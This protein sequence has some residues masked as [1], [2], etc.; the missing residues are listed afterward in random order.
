MGSWKTSLL[1][2]RNYR[3]Q[4]VLL[5]SSSLFI[6][7]VALTPPVSNFEQSPY[8]GYSTAVWVLFTI[9]MSGGITSLITAAKSH[10]YRHIW[11]A[12]LIA[13]VVSYGGLFAIPLVRDYAQYGG[14]GWDTFVHLGYTA[15]ILE[16]AELTSYRYPITHLTFS[17]L[18]LVTDIQP[19]TFTPVVAYIMFILFITSLAVAVRALTGDYRLTLMTAVAAVPIQFGNHI[20][21]IL[22][23]LQ[24]MTLLPL[25]LLATHGFMKNRNKRWA[26]VYLILSATLILYHPMTASIGILFITGY[27]VIN[28]RDGGIAQKQFVMLFATSLGLLGWHLFSGD[29]D[30]VI[31]S[32]ILRLLNPQPG[33][34]S[35]ATGSGLL[36]PP[37]HIAWLFLENYGILAL[38]F[39]FA[40]LIASYLL[41]CMI[42]N[43][44]PLF[45]QFIGTQFV[46]AG[47]VSVGMF[48]FRI[49][50]ENLVRVT[51]YLTLISVLV[52]GI[53]A[54]IGFDKIQQLDRW[55]KPIIVGIYIL[56]IITALFASGTVYT[57]N[58]HITHTTEMGYEWHVDHKTEIKTIDKK[59]R[60][61]MP[62]KFLGYKK[63]VNQ[64]YRLSMIFS[65]P[66]YPHRLGY[67]NN[68]SISKSLKLDPNE[69]MYLVT[70][71]EHIE[72]YRSLPNWKLESTTYY[73]PAD[74]KRLKNDKTANRVYSNGGLEISIIY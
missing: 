45:K 62:F 63:T 49:H 39:I 67:N 42:V 29:I 8:D 2:K 43:N 25:L 4:K 11:P 6:L 23:Y 68:T 38:Y 15:D 10:R 12:G 26:G 51:R 61:A 60:N 36:A 54:T 35:T 70:R 30:G 55:R 64:K 52:V 16:N 34:V 3:V 69:N 5:I 66:G 19:D 46:L 28:S 50:S 40:S 24:S 14:L 18:S 7:G 32:V 47:V 72:Q 48:L 74:R 20:F 17:E 1:N 59:G 22:P 65:S 71:D 21:G 57:Q 27:I 31:V 56:F 9:T 37:L 33:A 73:T 53:G 58:D 13:V 41:W 44:S